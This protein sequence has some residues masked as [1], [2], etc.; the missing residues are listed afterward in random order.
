MHFARETSAEGLGSRRE[1]GGH[2][3]VSVFDN[4]SKNSVIQESLQLE[5]SSHIVKVGVEATYLH[6][7]P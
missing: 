1:S 4:A 3:V 5:R 2:Y 7:N 6:F